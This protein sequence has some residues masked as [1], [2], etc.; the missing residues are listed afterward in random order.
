MQYRTMA[1]QH[2]TQPSSYRLSA[3]PVSDRNASGTLRPS[4][5]CQRGWS[6]PKHCPLP[7]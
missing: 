4:I 7:V 3:M 1:D 6:R 2:I 5:T